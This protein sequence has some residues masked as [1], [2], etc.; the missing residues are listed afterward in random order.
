MAN[1]IDMAT[2]ADVGN[3]ITPALTGQA[4][5]NA[6]P[7]LA[8]EI[9]ANSNT[10]QRYLAR[11]LPAITRVEV[12][13]GQGRASMRTL[14][15]PIVS[16]TLVQISAIGGSQVWTIVSPANGQGG[17]GFTYDKQ[18]INLQ[19]GWFGSIF[20]IGKQNIQITYTGGFITPGMIQIAILPTWVASQII[21]VGT[22]IQNAG[23]YYRCVVGGATGVSAPTWLTATNSITTEV[24]VS[25]AATWLCQ[26][27]VPPLPAAADHLPEDIQLSC[28][29]LTA[30][31]YKNATRVGDTGTGLGPDRVNYMLK[32]MSQPTIDRLNRHR[33]VFPIDGLS[34]Q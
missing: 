19:P 24:G 33:E 8:K 18:F 9:T 20:P 3:Y 16:V 27:V 30:L 7:V 34:T 1:L 4:L 25:P 23:F 15:S 2:L 13:N 11:N 17:L 31:T 22:Q 10:I 29:E 28:W 6:S 14:I 26:G 12:R 21:V 32:A 5:V